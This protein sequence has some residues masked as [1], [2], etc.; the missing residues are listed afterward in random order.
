MPNI[1]NLGSSFNVKLKAGVSVGQGTLVNVDSNGEGRLAD[2]SSS[3]WAHGI[4]FASGAGTK[5]AGMNQ[6]VRVDRAGLVTDVDYVTLTPGAKVYLGEDGKFA[7]SGTQ[8]VG[9]ALAS[10]K[11]LVDIDLQQV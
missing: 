8:V 9:L 7:T 10:D 11:V 5:T 4:A 1:A 2:H 6:Y 3:Y